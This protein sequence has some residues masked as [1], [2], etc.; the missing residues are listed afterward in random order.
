MDELAGLVLAVPQRPDHVRLGRVAALEADEDLVVP[1]HLLSIRKGA[2]VPWAKSQPPS[3]YYMQV[4]SSLARA[5]DFDLA[6][7][8]RD[9]PQEFGPYTTCYN[10]FVRWR[11]A[12]VW[13]R[14]LDAARE[15]FLS[16][17]NEILML[18]GILALAGAV[19]A[20]WLVRERDIER[21]DAERLRCRPSREQ[22]PGRRVLLGAQAL[23]ITHVTSVFEVIPG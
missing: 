21:A 8:W 13:D 22:A 1:N 20:L 7:P 12:G 9:L 4:L 2:V 23:G 19:A 16:G 15:G 6:V 17:M 5:Y 14:I 18:G 11:E 3:P 10:R